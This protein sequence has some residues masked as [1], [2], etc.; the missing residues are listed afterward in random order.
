MK[1]L[2]KY[3]AIVLSVTL[4][5]SVAIPLLAFA[6]PGEYLACGVCTCNCPEHTCVEGVRDILVGCNGCVL[7]GENSYDCA[8]HDNVTFCDGCMIGACHSSCKV[9]WHHDEQQ[10]ENHG[11]GGFGADGHHKHCFTCPGHSNY[12]K[13]ADDGKVVPI[14][15]CPGNCTPSTEPVPCA[16]PQCNCICACEPGDTEPGDTE[17]GDNEPGDTEPG[18]TEPGDTGGGGT[19]GGG[20]TTTP[21]V[22]PV[23]PIEP[24]APIVPIEPAVLIDFLETIV[25]T[26]GP[27]PLAA[28][29]PA[30]PEP[31]AEDDEIEIEEPMVPLAAPTSTDNDVG[32]G[33]PEAQEVITIDEQSV[34]LANIVVDTSSW[35]LWNLILSLA[36]V[37]LALMIGIRTMLKDKKENEDPEKHEETKRN[38]ILLSL[39]I[40]TLAIIG[41][42]LFILTQDIRL[43]MVMVDFWTLT[44]ATL[45]VCGLF[46]YIFA[47]RKEKDE[48][49]TTRKQIQIIR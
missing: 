29:P 11:G 2:K 41:V 32:L 21:P 14:Y 15:T 44:H 36:G 37:A 38:R 5:L 8:G 26:P 31:P 7:V 18:D 25:I 45:F 28:A 39:V 48:D 9:G 4:V 33:E 34:P 49:E 43:P 12:S 23:E 42:I 24:I 30:P 35:A 1:N 46:S 13:C 16:C 47:I 17:P 6:A 19:G 3:L 27:V 20:G 10:P 22:T 40:P